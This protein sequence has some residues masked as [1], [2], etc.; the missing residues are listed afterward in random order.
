MLNTNFNHK[1]LLNVQRANAFNLFEL[2]TLARNI[3]NIDGVRYGGYALCN[4][5]DSNEQE[6]GNWGL[7]RR[8]WMMG[9]GV[10]WD[11]T[12]VWWLEFDAV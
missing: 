9:F 4:V 10:E 1:I 5:V 12:R 11:G 3:S 7:R 8:G 6:K 2:L